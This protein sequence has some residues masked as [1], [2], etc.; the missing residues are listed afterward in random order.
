MGVQIFTRMMIGGTA[1]VVVRCGKV[2]AM[3]IKP[4][5]C[6]KYNYLFFDFIIVELKMQWVDVASRVALPKVLHTFVMNPMN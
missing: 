1:I 3:L 4:E 2:K 6:D 5:N